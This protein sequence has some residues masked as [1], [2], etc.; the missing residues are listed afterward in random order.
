M[1]YCQKPALALL[2]TSFFTP[3]AYMSKL[4]TPGHEKTRS[5]LCSGFL[6]VDKVIEI[7][8]LDFLKDLAEIVDLSINSSY[9]NLILPSR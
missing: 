8:Y 3:M 7:S 4:L 6:V 2:V 9:Y 5:T 1:L